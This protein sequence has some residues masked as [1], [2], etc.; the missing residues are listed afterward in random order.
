MCD[1]SDVHNSRNLIRFYLENSDKNAD[2][3]IR[4]YAGET[5]KALS[6]SVIYTCFA[7]HT[8]G[9]NSARSCWLP[10]ESSYWASEKDRKDSR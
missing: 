2:P 6:V 7:P 3:S 4:F 8:P 10:L 5:A 1:I 9:E